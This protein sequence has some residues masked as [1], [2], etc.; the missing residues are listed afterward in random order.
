MI[1]AADGTHAVHCGKD[2]APPQKRFSAASLI[3][4]RSQN[5]FLRQRRQMQL[6][7]PSLAPEHSAGACPQP[8]TQRRVSAVRPIAEQSNGF[9]LQPGAQKLFNV[10][11]F[12]LRD[13]PEAEDA[14]ALQR[15]TSCSRSRRCGSARQASH[16][17]T[18]GWQRSCNRKRKCGSVCQ[19][20]SLS[21]RSDYLCSWEPRSC[22][23][24]Q[25]SSW[26]AAR[27][28]FLQPKAQRRFNMTSRIL[29]CTKR[30]SLQPEMQKLFSVAG[31]IL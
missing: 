24:W 5:S 13:T 14:N 26:R 1:L 16:H 23:V 27:W 12:I 11:S 31:L 8:I 4:D 2:C 3:Q 10:A 21:T 15:G 19:V 22:S 25:A 29:K 7:V 18:Q 6:N 28:F 30:L 17:S 20:S 9:L